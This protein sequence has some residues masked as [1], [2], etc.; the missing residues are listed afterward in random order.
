MPLRIDT[1]RAAPAP[2]PVEEAPGTLVLLHGRGS[3]EEDLQGLRPWVGDHLSLVTP[4]APFPGAPWGYGSGWA[5]YRYLEEDRMVVETL[6]ESLEAMDHF[7]DGLGEVLGK[8][9]GRIVLG[10]FSQGGTLSLAYALTRPERVA[11]AVNLSGFLA[12][13]DAVQ[14]GLEGA[15]GFPVFWGHGHADPAIPFRLAERGRTALEAARADLT[16]HDHPSGHTI[17]RDEVEALQKW[18]AGVTKG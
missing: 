3:H 18:L 16:L 2:A 14:A 17:T 15:E 9:P 1:F 11:G 8:E 12:G 4:R 13:V 10:G 5:W 7:L 6:E